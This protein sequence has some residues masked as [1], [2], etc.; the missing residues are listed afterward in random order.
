MGLA[1]S[2]GVLAV[3]VVAAG[4][5]RLAEDL[6]VLLFNALLL[7]WLVLPVLTFSGDDLLDPTK[8]VLLPLT[9]RQLMTVMGVGAL[10]GVAPL[11]TLVAA[12]GL[13]PATGDGPLS[14]L[15]GLA[16]VGL[17][18]V[19]CVSA[20]RAVAAALSGLLRSR[21]GRDVGVA[22]AALLAVSAQLVNPLL[23]ASAASG[24]PGQDAL[25][26][27]AAPLRWTPAGLLATAPDRGP[28]GALAALAAVVLVVAVVVVWWERSLRTS[29]ERPDAAG[30]RRRRSTALEPRGVPL[31]AGRAGAVA[32]KDLR[33]LLREPR[34]LVNT[35]TSVLVPLL[36]VGIG[37]VL[38]AGGR[39]PPWLV[40]AVCG[41]GL[42]GG[43]AGSNRFGLDGSATWVLLSS[44]TD[45]RDAR[46]DLL[47]GDLAVV[48]VTVPVVVLGA[49]GLAAVTG[50]WAYVAP[51]LGVALAL[52][53]VAVA[54][55][56]AVAVRAPFPVPASSNAFS[57]G[58]AGQ[59]CAAGALTFVCL[60]GVVLAC[61]PLLALLVPA[62]RFDSP[63]WD[64]LLLVGGPAYGI[65]L[66]EVV[67]R[68]TA[69]TW[70][71]QAPEVLQ[72]LA[73][74][75]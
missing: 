26:A 57:S 32:A 43:F 34:R 14:V 52:L 35:M 74:D 58:S 33:Y 65:A 30:A 21:R 49:L 62:L 54:A 59:G 73:A 56:G 13:L 61:L 50:G 69:R 17:L 42:L 45:P 64:V 24:G 68:A 19:L 37:P 7:G 47:G 2:G 27:L 48:V 55:S 38:L 67:R 51:A 20:S 3:L 70:A 60:A 16:A 12:L 36:A 41:I 8:L 23:Q 10:V 5:G 66:G 6:V 9:R 71:V 40:F 46:R 28:L 11:A 72:V 75:R 29:L 1:V 53:A 4:P 31:P 63:V 44:A 22:L 25:A 15:V 18:L 39:P